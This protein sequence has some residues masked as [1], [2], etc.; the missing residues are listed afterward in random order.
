MVT[1][2]NGAFI[3]DEQAKIGIATHAFNYG[4]G[5]FEGI[6]GYW[7]VEREEIFIVRLEDHLRRMQRSCH[8]LR[9]DLGHEMP[10][11]C[12]IAVE[13]VRRGEY[14]QDVYIRPI[15]YKA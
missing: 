8:L 2:L 11:L 6:R 15:A 7:N 10:Q 1:W 3:P 5:C 14:R 13:L 12:D 9:I 4:T